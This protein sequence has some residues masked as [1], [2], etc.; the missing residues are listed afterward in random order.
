MK[1]EAREQH[2][3]PRH[4]RDRLE[5]LGRE[6]VPTRDERGQEPA[7]GIAVRAERRRGRVDGAL[8]H[9]RGTVV[10]GMRERRVG[11]DPFKAVL[12]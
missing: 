8:E 9:H 1:T 6:L 3:M 4:V 11:L 7:I 2:W 12:L 5:D 10:E